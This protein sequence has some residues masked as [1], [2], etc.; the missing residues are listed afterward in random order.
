MKEDA[1]AE[2]READATEQE[3]TA[4][5]LGPGNDVEATEEAMMETTGLPRGR[6]D[7]ESE[8][9]GRGLG[10][11]EIDT[12]EADGIEAGSGGVLL[13]RSDRIVLA[14]TDLLDAGGGDEKLA[15]PVDVGLFAMGAGDTAAEKSEVG[16][17]AG[18]M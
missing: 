10:K 16:F 7:G 13:S 5:G 4:L 6:G 17:H 9:G 8:I 18:D 12:C 14:A 3:D 1:G 11:I 15:I 2:Q